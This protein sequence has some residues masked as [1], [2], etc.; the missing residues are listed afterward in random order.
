M[1]LLPGMSLT[2]HKV[3]T[4]YL[5][6][7]SQLNQTQTETEVI[8]NE[9]NY[10]KALVVELLIEAQSVKFAHLSSCC[11]ENEMFSK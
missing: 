7:I 8:R 3:S 10:R 4:Y 1:I 9:S 2:I 11:T 5:S 6:T